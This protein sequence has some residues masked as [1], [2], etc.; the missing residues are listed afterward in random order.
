MFEIVE[1]HSP[2]FKGCKCNACVIGE[3]KYELA[4]GRPRYQTH[5]LLCE[6][7]LKD[8]R[9][10]LNEIKFEEEKP[11]TEEVVDERGLGN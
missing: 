11:K 3:A 9:D 4:I 6:Q 7:C 10:T 1:V 5:Y 2:Y 8:I